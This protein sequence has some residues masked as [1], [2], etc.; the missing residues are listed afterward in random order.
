MKIAGENIW[1]GMPVFWS[2]SI[3]IETTNGEIVS[4]KK[5]TI[6]I[7]WNDINS[8]LHP[9]GYAYRLDK[10]PPNISIDLVKI[11]EYKLNQLEI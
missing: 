8:P 5:D 2:S 6:N 4:F 7:K 1:V 9:N 10:L 3:N 11:R